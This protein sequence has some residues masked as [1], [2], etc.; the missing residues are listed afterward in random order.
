MSGIDLDARQGI[1]RLDD[2]FDADT[3]VGRLSAAGYEAVRVDR[4]PVFDRD[5][6]MHALYQA[7]ELPAWFGFNLDALAD[8]LN[9][10]EPKQG[11]RRVMVFQ[12]FTLLEDAD[13]DLAETFCE[14]VDEACLLPEAGLVAAILLQGRG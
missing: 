10:L 13:P 14:I 11:K 7:L 1:V 2:P 9:A 3:L 6:L 5:T 12:D 4:A 8:A